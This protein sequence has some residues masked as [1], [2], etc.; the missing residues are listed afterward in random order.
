MTERK[1]PP[2]ECSWVW[3]N[4]DADNNPKVKLGDLVAFEA[5][6]R[7]VFGTITQCDEDGVTI[8]EELSDPDPCA[9]CRIRDHWCCDPW[10]NPQD[11]EGDPHDHE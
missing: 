3:L 2:K 8:R 1:T 9:T 5:L 10:E 6:G 7:R 4:R 11:H